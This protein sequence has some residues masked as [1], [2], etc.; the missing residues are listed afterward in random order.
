MKLRTFCPTFKIESANMSLIINN[1]T[2]VLSTETIMSLYRNQQ[3]SCVAG[4]IHYGTDHSFNA[5]IYL[6]SCRLELKPSSH[7][8]KN[9]CFVLPGQMDCSCSS[10]LAGNQ[11][12]PFRLL[13][14]CSAGQKPAN[15]HQCTITWL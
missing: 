8:D 12:F 5:K 10:V 2:L 3:T 13:I 11:L 15:L 4:D 9:V 7:R 6:K 14:R 1:R